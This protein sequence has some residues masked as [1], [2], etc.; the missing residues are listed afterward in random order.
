MVWPGDGEGTAMLVRDAPLV[1]WPTCTAVDPVDPRLVVDLDR[2]CGEPGPYLVEVVGQR[3]HGGA[4]TVHA[5]FC[6]RHAAEFR[7]HPGAPPMLRRISTA[8]PSE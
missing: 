3:H 8:P 6:P 2:L 7:A 5:R 1:D 4:V